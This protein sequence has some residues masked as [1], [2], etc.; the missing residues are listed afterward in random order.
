[1]KSQAGDLKLVTKDEFTKAGFDSKFEPKK[2]NSSN[3]GFSL[4][5]QKD[6]IIGKFD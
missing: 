3:K 5:I 6:K 4:D 2:S 1:L